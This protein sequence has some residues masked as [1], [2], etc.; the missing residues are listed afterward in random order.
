MFDDAADAAQS[1]NMAQ[2]VTGDEKYIAAIGSYSS[3]CTLA[4][5][6]IFDEAQMP[7]MV[8]CASTAPSPQST[9]TPSSAA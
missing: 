2:I 6:S 7:V 4:F 8:P 9:I 3:T 5:G 1:T